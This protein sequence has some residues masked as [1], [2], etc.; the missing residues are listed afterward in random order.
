M[1]FGCP[2]LFLNYNR[3]HLTAQS[4]KAILDITPEKLYISCDGPKDNSIDQQKTKEVRNLFQALPKQIEVMFN[5]SDTNLGCKVGVS[6]GINWFFENEE[7]GIIIEDDVIPIPDFFFYAEKMLQK[8][9]GDERIMHI[10]GCNFVANVMKSKDKPIFFSVLP[11][12]WGWATWKRAWTSYSV[13]MEGYNAEINY[14]Y[15]RNEIIE[16]YFKA[17][18][19]KT[20][21]G[22]IDTWDYQWIYTIWKNGGLCITPKTHMIT[23]I[24]FGLDATHTS[25]APASLSNLKPIA[26]SLKDMNYN[27]SEIDHRLDKR[28]FV[29]HFVS[30][31]Q[32]SRKIKDKLKRFIGM[33]KRK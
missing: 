10:N 17:Q 32:P 12:V 15:V 9:H 33:V 24:G 25:Q 13:D 8:F 1:G 27:P 31:V 30:R 21:L 28:L 29:H 4:L 19:E 20:F 7:Y 18:F 23:N 16:Q 22:K 5:F 26:L 14:R 3:P 2:I 6:Q 11:F